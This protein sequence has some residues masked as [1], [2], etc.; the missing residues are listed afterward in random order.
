MSSDFLAI[1][2][3]AQPY[4]IS[5]AQRISGLQAGFDLSSP[6]DQQSRVVTLNIRW[7]DYGVSTVNNSRAI[8]IDLTAQQ[9]QQPLDRIRSIIIDNT[10]STI[11]IYVIFP[12]TQLTIPAEPGS[13]VV[14]QVLTG[15][16]QIFVYADGFIDGLIPTTQ[17]AL[18]NARLAPI[19][20]PTNYLPP[21][22]GTAVSGTT[23][24]DAVGG[25]QFVT[26]A[27]SL[28]TPADDR[29]VVACLQ[30]FAAPGVGTGAVSMT[31]MLLDAANMTLV[32]QAQSN[33]TRTS[34]AAIFQYAWPAGS[35]GVI[36]GNFSANVSGV[37]LE[38]YTLNNYNSP[39]PV[40]LS[41]AGALQSRTVSQEITNGGAGIF[42]GTAIS[43][44]AIP[45]PVWT[46]TGQIYNQPNGLVSPTSA[47]LTTAAFRSVANQTRAFTLNP[48]NV[49]VG[50]YWR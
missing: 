34:L 36:T 48:A 2:S 40:F 1:Q 15:Q 25:N 20:I 35:T 46:N 39:T 45:A 33:V 11:P 7:S 44:A 23:G 32:G 17:I 50:A 8:A 22:I 12:D 19:V 16:Q 47:W 9:V 6:P 10:F 18:T 49:L 24:Y 38:V 28:G 27:L 43:A 37:A 26:P 14:A 13:Y 42:G 29:L 41:S 31:S 21:I 30:A 4:K 5:A 3:V